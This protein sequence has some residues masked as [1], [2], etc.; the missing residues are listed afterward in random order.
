[1]D[2]KGYNIA[3]HEMGHNVEQTFSLNE[4][5]HWLLNGVPNTAFTE[6]IA[7]VFQAKDLEL[8]GLASPG[9]EAEALRTLNDF[10]TT[11]GIAGV[12]LVD[13][14]VWHWMYEHPDASAAE[15]KDATVRIAAETWNRYYAPV[16]G[17]RDVVLLGV[18]SHMIDSFL[19]LPD[20]PIGYFIAHQLEEHM[21]SVGKI[22]PEVERVARQGRIAPDLWM[23]GA[24]G[25]PV[26]PE[27]LLEATTRALGQVG[28]R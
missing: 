21:R 20:Y 10:W 9:A 12:G 13:M 7:F 22:G 8:L 28:A 27:A 17:Q 18:Y 25:A 2:Y 23:Q 5:D 1:M 15:L 6:A 4:I 14:A 16:F 11:Y 26:G 3:V 19:Y 24:T